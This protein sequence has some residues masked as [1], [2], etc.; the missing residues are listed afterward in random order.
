MVHVNITGAGFNN[1]QVIT[2]NIQIACLAV[3]DHNNDVNNQTGVDKFT[4]GTNEIDNMN[5]CL[6]VL[7]RMWLK[8]FTDFTEND[9][10]ASENP[11]LTPIYYSRTNLLDGWEL[12]F[13]ME[14]PNTTLNL[15]VN[16]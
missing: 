12:T 10:T 5:E 9:I 7:N 4:L 1:G 14:V 2:F 11:Q 3:R 6:A 8:M 13:D 16:P 15:C